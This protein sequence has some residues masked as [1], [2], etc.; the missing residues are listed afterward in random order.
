[1][2]RRERLVQDLNGDA[3][4]Q[5]RVLG[6]VDRSPAP[7]AGDRTDHIV[8]D[9]ATDHEGCRSKRRRP[10]GPRASATEAQLAG[11]CAAVAGRSVALRAEELHEVLEEDLVVERVARAR[12]VTEDLPDLVHMV[13]GDAAEEGAPACAG[14]ADEAV[15]GGLAAA[16]RLLVADEG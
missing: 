10:V 11:R 12:A 7:L 9:V 13:G 5:R 1:G 8:T 2:A 16:H 6:E 14:D 15:V 3:A 4:T